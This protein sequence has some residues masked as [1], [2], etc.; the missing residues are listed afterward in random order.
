M[1]PRYNRIQFYFFILDHT[2]TLKTNRIW[3]AAT[4]SN[5]NHMNLANFLKWPIVKSSRIRISQKPHHHHHH[6]PLFHPPVTIKLRRRISQ[7]I[8]RGALR[9][10]HCWNL[11]MSKTY[12]LKGTFRR[13]RAENFQTWPQN[14]CGVL[15]EDR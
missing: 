6:H 12:V 15:R 3:L 1:A 10:F 4:E 5:K 14:T 8:K 7:W 9:S 13:T 2:H 11:H